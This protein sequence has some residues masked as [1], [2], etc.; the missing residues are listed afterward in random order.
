MYSC[1]SLRSRC[2]TTAGLGSRVLPLAAKIGMKRCTSAWSIT[3][4]TAF[5]GWNAT[6]MA[7]QLQNDA[8]DVFGQGFEDLTA[9]TKEFEKLVLCGKL[10]HGGH[11]LLRW[12][13]SNDQA[14]MV[15]VSQVWYNDDEGAP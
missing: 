7:L 6:Q 14:L 1:I 5:T 3:R 15:L 8:F 4:E 9:P 12:M 10:R 13:A 11:R 2:P